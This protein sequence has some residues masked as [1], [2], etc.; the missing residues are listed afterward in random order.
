MDHSE[1]TMIQ[2]GQ[3]IWANETD[4]NGKIKK[5]STLGLSYFYATH[6]GYL[7]A[8]L[9]AYVNFQRNYIIL[10]LVKDPIIET[11]L[12]KP[13]EPEVAQK[14]SVIELVIVEQ[15]EQNL[16]DQLNNETIIICADGRCRYC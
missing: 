11:P 4:K 1:V 13:V 8:E 9:G 3:P 10:E 16:E 5:E 14:D 2:N 15:V 6:D 12:P 7:P